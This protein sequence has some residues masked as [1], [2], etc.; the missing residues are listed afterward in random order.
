MSED[1]PR[2]PADDL[3]DYLA[4]RKANDK[5]E[6]TTTDYL[7]GVFHTTPLHPDFLVALT[8]LLWPRF[9]EV[10]GGVF[11]AAHFDAARHEELLASC[12]TTRER[13][14]WMNLVILD[15]LFDAPDGTFFSQ[16][17]A[18]LLSAAAA[19]WRTRLQEAFP[20]RAFEV[21]AIEDHEA[22]DYGLTFTQTTSSPA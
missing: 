9:V 18:A 7:V 21:T 14:F 1:G 4:W 3:P 12:A 8:E 15:R 11:H 19:M 16:H 2:V 5:T 6:F 13:E 20:D 17:A 10:E 22:G